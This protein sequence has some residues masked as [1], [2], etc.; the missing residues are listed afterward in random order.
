MYKEPF[1]DISPEFIPSASCFYFSN[2][3][4]LCTHFS[5]VFTMFWWWV[6]N[7]IFPSDC[8][9]EEALCPACL[10]VSGDKHGKNDWMKG[11]YFWGTEWLL[12]IPTKQEIVRKNKQKVFY[13]LPCCRPQ[14]SILMGRTQ[15]L[16]NLS[17]NQLLL[18]NGFT[19][20]RSKIT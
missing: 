4:A 6:Y 13:S 2:H 1:F 12:F 10:Y 17:P 11:Q 14:E 16:L 9:P 19:L 18:C 20:P 5:Q 8:A 7:H 15:K 3:M